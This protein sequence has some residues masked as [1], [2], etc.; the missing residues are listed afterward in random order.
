[1]DDLEE[2]PWFVFAKPL[3]MVYVPAATEEEARRKLVA[4]CYDDAPVDDWPCVGSRF[5][6]RQALAESLL[7]ARDPSKG[8]LANGGGR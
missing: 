8:T 6:S 5:T 3:A 4:N 7:R 1:M 2:R